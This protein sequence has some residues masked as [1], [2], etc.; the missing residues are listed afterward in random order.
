M[1]AVVP[2]LH[3]NLSLG[4]GLAVLVPFYFVC[5]RAYSVYLGP[6]S[7]FPGPKLAAATLWYE[8]YY[9]VILQGRY[10]FKIKELH[11]EYGIFCPRLILTE[12]KLTLPGPI[13]RIS[14]YELHID[15]P[16]YYE[17][18]YSQHKP[19]NKSEFYLNQFGLP[20]AGFGTAD[21]KL[22]R[23]R[24]AAMNPFLSKRSVERLQPMLNFMIEKLCGRI[25]EY[26][27]TAE[28]MSMRQVFM[29]LTT[30]V[31]TLYALNR[32]WNHLDSK[33][34]SPVWV[35]TIKATASAGHIMKQFP[36]I[37][38]II[39]ALPRSVVRA[40]DPGMLLL[41]EFQDVS[42]SSIFLLAILHEES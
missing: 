9:D 2:V 18:L 15:E 16:D 38:P 40:M 20:G 24:R 31:V 21:H 34:F 28:P 41:L 12:T 1:A 42:A 26:R 4:L 33:D 7:K 36:F 30:D 37:F 19:R 5:R 23:A 22:H 25:E 13:V 17:E 39:R 29:C 10:T 3:Q 11:E 14:P 8:F 27:A 35:E 6:L 32:S